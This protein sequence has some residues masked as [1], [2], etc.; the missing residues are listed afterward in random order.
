MTDGW[1]ETSRIPSTR[2]VCPDCGA[3]STQLGDRAVE[4]SLDPVVDPE[5]GLRIRAEARC[6][7]GWSDRFEITAD[8]VG[9]DDD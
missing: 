1:P 2:D 5:D 6:P 3:D 8:N 4:T 9:W 7:C